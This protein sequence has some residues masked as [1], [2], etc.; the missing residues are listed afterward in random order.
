MSTTA[1]AR[2]AAVYATKSRRHRR[3]AFL[4]SNLP[5][6]LPPSA[7]RWCCHE[8]VRHILSVLPGILRG[9]RLDIG[10][11]NARAR[12]LRGV[13][14]LSGILGGTRVAGVPPGAVLGAKI[15][16]RPGAAAARKLR[17]SIEFRTLASAGEAARHTTAVTTRCR[18]CKVCD[19]I[20]VFLSTDIECCSARVGE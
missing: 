9:C 8:A 15:F 4:A 3:K 17:R 2:Q 6:S 5:R 11:G 10:Q 20:F 19:R 18:S 16:C 12:A 1:I 7:N 14:Q 13:R